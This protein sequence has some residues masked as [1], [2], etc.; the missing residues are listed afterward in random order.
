M[1]VEDA[2]QL[3]GDLEGTEKHK[4]DDKYKTLFQLFP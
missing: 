3:K 1:K 2:G 4:L